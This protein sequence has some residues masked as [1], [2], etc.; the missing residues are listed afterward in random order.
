[1]SLARDVADMRRAADV[2]EHAN[3]APVARLL[4]DIARAAEQAGVGPISSGEQ[5]RWTP[6]VAHAAGFSRDTLDAAPHLYP[7]V[8]EPAQDID[9]IVAASEP[10]LDALL[11]DLARDAADVV[12]RA[13]AADIENN[14]P[15]DGAR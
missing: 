14:R 4:R 5:A 2:F 13:V 10:N 9:A 3:A 7:G 12:R 1:M 8:F 6:V 15:A 11:A